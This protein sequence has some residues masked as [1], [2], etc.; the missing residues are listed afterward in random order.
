V[1]AYTRRQVVQGAGAVGL[2]LLV[3]CGR[4]PRQG[5]RPTELPRVGFLSIGVDEITSA[6]AAIPGSRTYAWL[7]AGL[8]E[9]GYLPG[10]HYVPEPRVTPQGEGRL[11]ELAAELVQTG[12]AVIVATS[13]T[14]RPA[15]QATKTT[16]IVLLGGPDPVAEG[17][18]GSL[19]QP[20][21]NVTGV[22]AE[23]QGGMI[24]KRWEIFKDVVPGLSRLAIIRDTNFGA[25]TAAQVSAAQALGLE[26]VFQDVQRA[27]EIESAVDAAVAERAEGLFF[28]QAGVFGRRLP[29][30][31][32][33]GLRHRLPTMALFRNFTEAGGLMAYG[34]RLEWVAKRAAYYVDR[35]LK[36]AKP[37][38]LPVEQPREFEFVI[39]AKTAQALGLT[40]PPHVLLQATEVIQ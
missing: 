22:P 13:G 25:P 39:N 40:I 12:V 8:R 35:I 38:D 14:V 1:T 6:G 20:G 28:Y 19:A 5:V 34:A 18:V 33:L 24:G 21:G 30:M 2:G 23:V 32:Q 27:E 4:L 9:L 26:L 16:P 11:R 31:A 15:I 29:E 36:G 7:E 10:Q 17:F 37:A 3:G